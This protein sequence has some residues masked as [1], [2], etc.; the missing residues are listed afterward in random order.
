MLDEEAQSPART[1]ITRRMAHVSHK[2]SG[3]LEGA[4]AGGGDPA[5]S[6]LYVFGPFL[7][8]LV[9][10]GATSV[11]FGA[12]IWLAV[13]TVI[14]VSAMY[15]RVMLWVTDGS[16]GS[17]LSEDEFGPW[18]VK[19]NAGITVV[20]YTLTFLVSIA[21]LVTFIGDRFPLLAGHVV[22]IPLRTVIAV[23]LSVVTGFAVNRGPKVAARAFG[24]ATAAI[25][26]LLWVMIIV[27]I[28]R[29]GFHLPALDLRAFTRPYLGATL[30][31]YARILALMTGI[32]IF[33]NLV[34]A[35]RGTARERSRKA[36]GS[37]VIVMGTTS[38]TMIVVGPAIRDLSNP[39]DP[40]VSVFTQTMDRLLPGPLAYAGTLIGIA[41]LLSA[42][43]ASAQGIQNLAL[44]LR[45]RHYIPASFGRK[46]RYDVAD[47]PV[48]LEIGI[49][50][51]CF[52][53]LG[54]HEETYLALYAAGVFVLLSLT[55]W[56]A[57]KRLTR[58]LRASP[59]SSLA[60]SLLGT[61]I[62][63]LL[64]SGATLVIFGERFLEGAWTYFVMIPV[65]YGVFGWFRKRLGPP[66]P[67]EDRLGMLIGSAPVAHPSATPETT[68][69][70]RHIVLPL[71]G[72]ALA[73]AAFPLAHWL[74]RGYGC[75][76]TLLSIVET[77][78]RRD[79]A[80][81]DTQRYLEE[82]AVDLRSAGH[83][84]A[85]EVRRGDLAEQIGRVA[86][87]DGVDLMIMTTGGRSRLQR[88][89][90]SSVTTGVIY[91]TT[92]PLIVLRP[93]EDWH[94]TR[95]QFA[96]LL[97]ALDGSELAE[98]ILPYVRELAARFGG[99][100]ILVSVPE[101]SESD[102]IV[103]HLETYLD[104]I[105]ESLGRD[106][107]V[108]RRLVVGGE[109][110][111]GILD[112]ARDER[113]DLVMMVSHGRGGVA[114]QEHVPLGSVVDEIIQEAC[115][116]IFLVSATT[117]ETPVRSSPDDRPAPLPAR[118]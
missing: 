105:V 19:V 40:S 23:A 115:C 31:G 49:C 17:G 59:S 29:R 64:T 79:D 75:R 96:R 72:S 33:A 71:N 51:V 99:E 22:G 104:R 87:N 100:V 44:G 107:I 10:A 110:T 80:D 15:R 60:L 61:L 95:T 8:L 62:A 13:L 67:V 16:G 56:A 86:K 25:L 32:E 57:V 116:P 98:Q 106:G 53:L 82:A 117:P 36:F 91:Q 83:E 34:A 78:D 24:P 45:H 114:R 74:A 9:V 47:K 88:W 58:E 1:V 69:A 27:T 2:L 42:A 55:G 30:G 12:S 35:Y 14:T 3:S 103:E 50:V 26:L 118:H 65:L 7:R 37:L 73:E 77:A 84:V 54:T 63:V 97:V 109:P 11:T 21:A 81:A 76:L 111:R 94:A 68:T 102:G 28:V 38:A 90:A 92:P 5:T 112:A 52:A 108:A 39:L 6:P 4:L 66:T 18:A 43:A 48:W 93:G 70:F 113:C 101:G 20:E 85:I 89:F 41:V 46:N